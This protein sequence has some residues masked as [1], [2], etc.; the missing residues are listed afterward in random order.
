MLGTHTAPPLASLWPPTVV[1]PACRLCGARLQRTLIDLGSL[2]LANGTVAAHAARDRSYRLHV[3]ICDDCTLAQI[4]DAPP[5]GPSSLP[6]GYRTRSVAYAGTM[7]NRLRL[8]AESLVIEVGSNDGT[9]L[10][11]FQA[12]GVPV[13]RIE[14]ATAPFDIEAAMEV[15][16]RRGRAD[17]VVAHDVLQYVPDPFDFAAGLASI[18]RPNGIVSVQVPHL[19]SIV[20]KAQFDAFR[21]D[22]LSYF[23]LG[24]LEHML[25]SVGLR[26]F[27]AE[28]P[29]DDGG[30]LRVHAC[31]AVAP[32]SARHGLK[33]V[34]L[35]E[36]FA[37]L[38]RRDFHAGF[39]ERVAL[40]QADIREFLRSKLATGRRVAAYGAVTRGTMLLS[41]C[42]ITA[43]DIGC[44]AAP[45]PARHGR[46]LPGSRI[47]IVPLETLI[48]DPPDDLV[49]LPWPDAG[50]IA[51]E[52]TGLRQ[53]G[54][55]LWT[56]L[57][58][59]A[60]V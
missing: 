46:L 19:L 36:G 11:P 49:I 20:Q 22:C 12:A 31:H 45:D 8:G 27:D 37:E 44:V 51:V 13:L 59:I 52:L 26:V 58:R 43:R 6:A 42:G 30:S 54:T 1:E 34:R 29:P 55:L 10:P 50:D 41:C 40:V 9:M 32:Y 23:S 53:R 28:R 5:P 7:L 24:V 60:R 39:S 17:F 16:V 25:R 18:L 14:P 56:L 38:D 47:P 35:A 48:A 33:A 15:A 57:P 21:H 3:R 2:P 4:A